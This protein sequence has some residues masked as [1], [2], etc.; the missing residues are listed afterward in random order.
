MKR[1]VDELFKK[2]ADKN[3]T[4]LN[5]AKIQPIHKSLLFSQN[6]IWVM[7][8]T[9]NSGKTFNYLKLTANMKTYLMILFSK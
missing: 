6:G 5:N 9:M 3:K 2:L 4:E 7:I 8:G 1:D